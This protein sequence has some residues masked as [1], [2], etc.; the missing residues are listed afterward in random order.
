MTLQISYDLM[1]S[2]TY[3]YIDIC[4]E[5]HFCPPAVLHLEDARHAR[6]CLTFVLQRFEQQ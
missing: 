5:F 4:R 3:F 6:V 2:F 1:N